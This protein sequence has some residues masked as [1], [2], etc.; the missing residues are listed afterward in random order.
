MH[1]EKI[2]VIQLAVSLEYTKLPTP[3]SDIIK[4]NSS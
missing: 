3:F 1:I 4:T 2:D